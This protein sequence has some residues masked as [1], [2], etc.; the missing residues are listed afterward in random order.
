LKAEF[1]I[2]DEKNVYYHCISNQYYAE[3]CMILCNM[4]IKY[5]NKYKIIFYDLQK[6]N[7]VFLQY[8]SESREYLHFPINYAF[9]F[10]CFSNHV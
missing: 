6:R 7:T 8:F 10:M 5:E 4:N 3:F 2:F 1:A 9:I